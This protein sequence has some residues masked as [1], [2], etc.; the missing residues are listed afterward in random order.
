MITESIVILINVSNNKKIGGFPASCLP[1]DEDFY[2]FQ[3]LRDD[4]V[5]GASVPFQLRGGEELC[6]VEVSPFIF[7]CCCS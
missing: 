6:A 4:Q 2:Q 7:C 1:K 3:Y 5:F